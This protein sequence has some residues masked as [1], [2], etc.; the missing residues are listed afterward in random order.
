MAGSGWRDNSGRWSVADGIE[1]CEQAVRAAESRK[2]KTKPN[3]SGV[4]PCWIGTW[5]ETRPDRS[6]KQSRS[7]VR[8]LAA[9]TRYRPLVTDH[10][11]PAPFYS[12]RADCLGVAR[13]VDNEALGQPGR[14]TAGLGRDS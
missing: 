9:F 11:S 4:N 1:V 3:R 13:V 12:P 14:T 5:D 7:A 10:S 6:G 8:R 2:R